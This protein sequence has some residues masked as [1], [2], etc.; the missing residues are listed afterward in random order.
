[1]KPNDLFDIAVMKNHMTSLMVAASICI[2]PAI[3]NSSPAL[4]ATIDD[5]IEQQGISAVTQSELG[6]SIRR[7]VVG[8]AKVVD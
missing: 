1:M 7:Q 6:K 4:A 8:G 2:V 3:S 5:R